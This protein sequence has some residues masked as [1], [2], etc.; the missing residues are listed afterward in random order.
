VYRK[1]CALYILCPNLRVGTERTNERSDCC[2]VIARQGKHHAQEIAAIARKT[3]CIFYCLS[4]NAI[5]LAL[6]FFLNW[7][8]QLR[9]TCDGFAGCGLKERIVL[10]WKQGLTSNLQSS[11]C[12]CGRPIVNLCDDRHDDGWGPC[13][14]VRVN[15]RSVVDVCIIVN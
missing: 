6:P 11:V 2:R 1:L 14:S 3:N 8:D 5:Y 13:I 7:N 4:I 9:I 15:F 12:H 10:G